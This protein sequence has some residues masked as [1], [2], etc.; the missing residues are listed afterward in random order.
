V[1]IL[2]FVAAFSDNIALCLFQGFLLFTVLIQYGFDL[3]CKILFV[4][5][6]Y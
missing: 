1:T 3:C 5:T 4:M 6:L 2:E